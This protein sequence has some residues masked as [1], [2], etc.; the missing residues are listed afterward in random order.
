MD[1][2]IVSYKG[3]HQDSITIRSKP[4]LTGALYYCGADPFGYLFNLRFRI[5]RRYR[6]KAI[7]LELMTPLY[8]S[9]R[10]VYTDNAY[11][12]LE[13]ARELLLQDIKITGTAKVNAAKKLFENY[14]HPQVKR[15]SWF[16]AR[17]GGIVACTY[18]D[19]HQNNTAHL[20]NFITTG[21]SA[22]VTDAHRPW[23][24]HCYN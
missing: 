16:S 9:W 2:G 13:L 22:I 11:T 3:Y 17:C 1:E 14:S 19:V 15:G 21:H 10:H 18:S 7:V 5:G 4:N 24:S 23:V 20:V 12:S 8:H 6:M